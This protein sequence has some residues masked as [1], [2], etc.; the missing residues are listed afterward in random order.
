VRAY[1]RNHKNRTG[2]LSAAERELATA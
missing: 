1:E 2:V